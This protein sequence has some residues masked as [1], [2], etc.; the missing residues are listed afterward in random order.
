MESIRE[1]FNVRVLTRIVVAFLGY[2]IARVVHEYLLGRIKAITTIPEISDAITMIVGA[3]FLRGDI[4][5]AFL[6]GSGL[7][8]L[9]HL[10]ARLGLSWL[11]K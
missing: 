8:L 6:T 7:S 9:N 5:E 3:Y 11:Q 2:F 4:Q 1:A 10:I